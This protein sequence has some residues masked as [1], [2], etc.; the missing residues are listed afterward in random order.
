MK[1]ESKYHFK[2]NWNGSEQYY[3]NLSD[4][5]IDA[6]RDGTHKGC[7]I[8]LGSHFLFVIFSKVVYS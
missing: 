5:I 6:E 4:A 3:N 8:Y 2:S 7:S 1:T